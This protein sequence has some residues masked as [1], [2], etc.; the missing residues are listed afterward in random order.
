MIA[1]TILPLVT[2]NGDPQKAIAYASVLALFTGAIMVAAGAAC[3]GFVAD[4]LSKPTIL[5]YMNGLALTI[6]IGQLP[7]LLG[8]SVDADKF[9][10]E[11]AGLFQ[12]IVGGKVVPRPPPSGSSAWR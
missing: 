5:G 12:G 4:L 8:F 2:A 3:A 6:L 11:L 7:K 1:A 10:G 9:L